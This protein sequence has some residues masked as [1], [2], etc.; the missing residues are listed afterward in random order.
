MF[1]KGSA[2]GSVSVRDAGGREQELPA[3]A[4]VVAPNLRSLSRVVD[5]LKDSAPEV[6]V[7]GDCRAPRI[8]FDAIHEAFEAA[9][10]M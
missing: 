6:H 7:V 4:V 2:R 1:W 10:E 3:D 9:L 5:D 8:L